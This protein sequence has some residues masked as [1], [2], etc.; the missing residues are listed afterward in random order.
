MRCQDLRKNLLSILVQCNEW[1]EATSSLCGRFHASEV[2]LLPAKVDADAGEAVDD[3]PESGG[4]AMSCFVDTVPDGALASWT[5]A[6][7]KKKGNLRIE[8]RM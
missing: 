5:V 1:C 4:D 3:P 7:A 6:L 2:G 8:V